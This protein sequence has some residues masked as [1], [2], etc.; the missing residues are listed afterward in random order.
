MR[1]TLV[2]VVGLLAIAGTSARAFDQQ[3]KIVPEAPAASVQEQSTA[4]SESSEPTVQVPGIGNLGVIPKL[5][6]GLELLYGA[7]TE[8]R[9]VQTEPQADEDG[10]R[11][12]GTVR[13]RF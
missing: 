10:L 11:I 1:R 2:A 9:T 7:E 5:D 8:Q 6:F 13:H 12:R 3:T 4:K